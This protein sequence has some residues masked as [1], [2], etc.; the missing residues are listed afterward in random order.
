MIA[1]HWSKQAN[2]T[3]TL[4]E[5]AGTGVRGAERDRAQVKGT[6]FGLPGY[7]ERAVQSNRVQ[8]RAELDAETLYNLELDPL[9][10]ILTAQQI[11]AKTGE[12]PRYEFEKLVLDSGFV[13]YYAQ[14]VVKV[15]VPVRV[16]KED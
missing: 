16:Q 14:S 6:Y 2:L 5:F 8:Y 15:F 10:F 3:V 12:N 11:A 9:G 13:G 4:P 1:Y 7:V